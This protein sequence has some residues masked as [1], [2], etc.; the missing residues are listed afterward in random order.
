[1]KYEALFSSKDRSKKLKC[2]LLQFFCGALRFKNSTHKG[3][4]PVMVLYFCPTFGS[5]LWPS[6]ETSLTGQKQPVEQALSKKAKHTFLFHF[7]VHSLSLSPSHYPDM[8][9]TSY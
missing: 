5:R 8:T 1:M 4:V 7:F 6:C 9:E 3:N 2:R